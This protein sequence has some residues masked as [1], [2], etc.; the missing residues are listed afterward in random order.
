MAGSLLLHVALFGLSYYPRSASPRVLA[1]RSAPEPQLELDVVLESPGVALPPEPDAPSAELA[2]ASQLGAR[3]R[4]RERGAIAGGSATSASSPDLSSEADADAEAGGLAT[5]DEAAAGAD[6][7][8]TG[9]RLSL[10]ELGVGEG[11]PFVD[12]DSAAR[13]AARKKADKTR[14]VKRRLDRALAQGLLDRDSARGH[15]AGSPVMRLLEAATYAS[16]TPGNGNASFTFIIDSDGKVVSGSLGAT[17]SARET[18]ERVLRK[19]LHDLVSHELRVPQGKGVKLTV[20]VSSRIELPSGADPGLEV[21]AL[22]IPLA[23]GAGPRSTRVDILNPLNPLAPLSLL[24]D[25]AD[26][27]ATARRMVRAHVTSEE[28]M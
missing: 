28:L 20:H 4:P 24:G 23:R 2:A 25:P 7:S 8:V 14:A 5:S 27:A 21:R 13:S 16:A 1:H 19:A 26:L 12:R 6:A 9:P 22:G 15:G 10:A 17:S 3:P 11:N 18:W